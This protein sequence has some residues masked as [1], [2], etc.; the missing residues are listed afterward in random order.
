MA[1]S[2]GEIQNVMAMDIEI[3]EDIFSYYASRTASHFGFTGPS[4]VYDN[5]CSSSL[6]AFYSAVLSIKHNECDQAIV[7]AVNLTLGPQMCMF[8]KQ[9]NA[10][11]P[12]SLCLVW[13]ENSNGYVRGIENFHGIYFNYY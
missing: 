12:D 3:K 6:L 8:L 4:G 11:S 9:L 5:M 7:A 2:S 10:L 13:D 1:S